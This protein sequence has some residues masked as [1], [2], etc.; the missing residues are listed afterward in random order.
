MNSEACNDRSGI[1]REQ[2]IRAS[3]FFPCVFQHGWSRNCQ[4]L[5]GRTV[6]RTVTPGITTAGVDTWSFS[7]VGSHCLKIMPPFSNAQIFKSS[8]HQ[9]LKACCNGL[10]CNCSGQQRM[11]ERNIFHSFKVIS[12]LSTAESTLNHMCGSLNPIRFG[13][14]SQRSKLLHLNGCPEKPG[15]KTF[16]RRCSIFGKVRQGAIHATCGGAFQF[17][18][19]L[20]L[21]AY[22]QK[23]ESS[24]KKRFNLPS[25]TNA[26][27]VVI[28]WTC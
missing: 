26:S 4:R 28:G 3:Y 12:Q 13:Q 22:R 6:S 23:K 7:N 2:E 15:Q 10:C 8:N 14:S 24:S 20:H 19:C 11:P 27:Q 5:Y 9:M 16:T 21:P 18:F 1:D 25:I 17:R